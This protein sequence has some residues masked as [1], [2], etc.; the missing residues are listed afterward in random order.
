MSTLVIQGLVISGNTTLDE[1]DTLHL[2]CDASTLRHDA[3]VKWLSPEG[4]VISKKRILEIV[5]IQRSAAGMYTCVAT[6]HRIL[7]TTISVNVTVQC[8]YYE[9]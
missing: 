4:A 3:S 6:R 9:E 7:T 8:E 1:G 5:N 2:D